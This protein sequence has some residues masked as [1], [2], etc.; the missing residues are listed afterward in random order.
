MEYCFLDVFKNSFVYLNVDLHIFNKLFVLC[1]GGRLTV[2]VN[3]ASQITSAKYFVIDISQTR[4]LNRCFVNVVGYAPPK[5]L[6]L[7]VP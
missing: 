1:F 5:K 2:F 3:S 4:N 6:L 7:K